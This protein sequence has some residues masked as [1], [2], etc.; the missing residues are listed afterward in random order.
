MTMA[1]MAGDRQFGL[2]LPDTRPDPTVIDPDTV[3]AELEAVLAAARAED[4]GSAWDRRT[5]EYYRL[6][7]P[8]MARWLPAAEA[9]QVISR[10][11]HEM[12]RIETMSVA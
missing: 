2:G 9:D 1:T 6:V 3:R 10:F 5:R 12:N 4:P 7:V 11:S 8:Q